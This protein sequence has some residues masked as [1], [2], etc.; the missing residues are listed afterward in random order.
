MDMSHPFHLVFVDAFFLLGAMLGQ[1]V[2]SPCIE[3]V[4]MKDLDKRMQKEVECIIFYS[5][6]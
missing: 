4:H 1:G 2:S 3:V 6:P 5:V